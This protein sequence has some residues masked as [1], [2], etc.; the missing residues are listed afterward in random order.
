MQSLSCCTLANNPS[1]SSA[2]HSLQSSVFLSVTWRVMVWVS[3]LCHTS[4]YL[5]RNTCCKIWCSLNMGSAK[6]TCID[7]MCGGQPH[8]SMKQEFLYPPTYIEKARKYESPSGNWKVQDK[9]FR[10]HGTLEKMH[11]RSISNSR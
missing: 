10:I 9:V 4:V 1:K 2:K 3:S 11:T 7:Y 8:L 6:Y 5:L